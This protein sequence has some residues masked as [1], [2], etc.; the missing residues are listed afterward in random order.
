MTQFFNLS[1]TVSVRP[2]HCMLKDLYPDGF[3]QPPGLDNRD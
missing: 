3:A 1:V 2:P